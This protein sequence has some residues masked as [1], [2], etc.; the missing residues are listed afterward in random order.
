MTYDIN[1][2]YRLRYH[3]PYCILILVNDVYEDQS[4]GTNV[5]NKIR[6]AGNIHS[7]ER[8]ASPQSKKRNEDL[9]C[10]VRVDLK[11]LLLYLSADH[12]VPKR[13][14]A[15]FVEG[16]LIH[17]FL[18]HDNICIQYLLPAVLE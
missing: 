14:L 11:K 17:L 5:A 8:D 6:L 15:N 1:N 16:K 13:T 9:F 10:D 7:N 12:I 4:N 18:I 2:F 3:K